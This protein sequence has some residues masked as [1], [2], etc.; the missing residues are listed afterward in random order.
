MLSCPKLVR[1][2]IVLALVTSLAVANDAPTPPNP[3]AEVMPDIG[4]AILRDWI[5]PEYPAEAR[6]AKAEGTVTVRFVVETDG[7]VSRENVGKSSDDRFNEAA[8]AAVRRW[9]FK[10]ATEDG[11]T[12][13]S[14]MQVK[15]VFALAQLNQKSVPIYPPQAQ[16]PVAFKVTPAKEKGSIDPDYPAELEETKLPGEVHM[17]FIVNEEGKVEQPRV[18]W[19]THP[20]FVET[21]LR[22]IRR[23]EFAPAHQGPLPRRSVKRYP[24]GFESFG[25][26][27]ADILAANHL[28]IVSQ[29][30]PVI[31]PRPLMLIQPVY[32]PARYQARETGSVTA[33]FVLDEKGRPTHIGVVAADQPEFGAAMVAAIEAWVFKPAQGDNGPVPVRL[34]VTHDFAVLSDQ[35]EYRLAELLKPDGPGISGPAGLDQKV[36]PLWRGFPAYPQAYKDQPR[37]G[38]AQIEFIIDRNGRSRLPRILSS[39]DEAFGWAAVT[40]ISQWVFERPTRGGAPTDI[41]VRIPVG[42]TPPPKE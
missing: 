24:V 41:K 39:T 33:E 19:A 32:P 29:E 16:Q 30:P 36:T 10:P 34:R 18:L 15:V 25:A 21:S 35:P 8:L 42:F 13:A 2:V 14:A 31:L 5:Q 3:D 27:P 9:K 23:A 12:I 22:A 20:A 37:D 40:A 7:T 26:K 6:K 28:T 38:Q 11:A 4:P 1:A 17:E